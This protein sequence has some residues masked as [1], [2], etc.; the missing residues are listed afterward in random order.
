MSDTRTEAE[1][2][3]QLLDDYIV[4]SCAYVA[5]ANAR[6]L[7]ELMERATRLRGFLDSTEAALIRRAD[8][9]AA[10][11]Q[12]GDGIDLSRKTARRSSHKSRKRQRRAKTLGDAPKLDDS[13]GDGKI[14]PDHV[15]V[16]SNTA[17]NLSPEN[18]DEFISRA[19]DELVPE[20]ERL[21]PESFARVARDLADEIEN[22]DRV[23][24][25][26][27]QKA[28]T[29]LNTWTNKG[30]MGV[31]N[32]EFDPETFA[33]ITTALQAEYDTL[34]HA[35]ANNQLAIPDGVR[36]KTGWLR[37]Q[38]LANLITGAR[39]TNQRVPELL[40][41]IDWETL[42]GQLPDG[43]CTL[44]DGTTIPV[45]TARR[46]ACDANIIPVVLGGPS[47]L[48]DVGTSHRTATRPQRRALR[49]LYATC[50][51]CD[52][53]FDWCQIHHITHWCNNGPTDLQNLG[54]VC[55]RHHHLLHEGKH[56]ITRNADNTLSLVAPT[57]EILFRTA[58]PHPPPTHPEPSQAGPRE[59]PTKGND[60]TREPS[61]RP[62]RNQTPTPNQSPETQLAFTAAIDP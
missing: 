15:D 33:R 3:E 59:K 30:G 44:G 12:G 40:A 43:V 60:Q 41:L 29:F 26:Q 52:T 42:K 50:M 45:S 21:T 46:L 37:A 36:S 54:P 55:N 48:I 53:P 49:A 5:G 61:K 32:G 1:R 11:G 22:D 28:N 7:A 18:R 27:R 31:L 17:E 34:F 23:D 58:V 51:F 6:Y 16:V 38:A 14:S 25:L 62:A 35:H 20:A 8:E 39:T 47:D 13:L 24:K 9:L 10:E 56:T 4:V 2:T 19:D 57:G